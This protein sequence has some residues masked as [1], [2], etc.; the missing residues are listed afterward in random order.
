MTGSN[1]T[2]FSAQDLFWLLPLVAAIVLPGLSYIMA[3]HPFAARIRLAVVMDS[4]VAVVTAIVFVIVYLASG[5][6]LR[7][8]LSV[9]TI[10]SL[11]LFQW[12]LLNT[13]AGVLAESLPIGILADAVPVAIGFGLLW[14]ATRLGEERPFVAVVAGG[15]WA[16]IIAL[17]VM[18]VP[19]VERVPGSTGEAQ[20]AGG[21][22]DVV[23]LILDGYPRADVLDAQFGYD[24][25]PFLDDLAALGFEVADEANSNYSFTYAA[26]SSMLQLDYIFEPGPINDEQREQMRNAL[27]G[28]SPMMR[29]FSE[30]GYEIAYYENAWEGSSCSPYVDDCVRDGLVERTLWNL[31]RSTIFAKLYD[32][33]RPNPFASVSLAHLES[34]GTVT[35]RPNDGKVPRF[36]ILHA[37]LPHQPILLSAECKIVRAT[38]DGG[39]AANT[40]ELRDAAKGLYEEQLDCV[41][42]LVIS[43]LQELISANPGTMVMITG[44]HG[45]GSLLAEGN[46]TIS[47]LPQA[48]FE[49]M[50]ILS[51]YRLPGCEDR[52]YPAITP[53]NGT[54]ALTEC[55]L[56]TSYPALPDRSMWATED[57]FGV[58]VD[59]AGRIPESG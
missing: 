1:R 36:T 8:S 35:R 16:T 30:A 39:F 6:R 14:V 3:G 44:D 25:T 43:G 28:D 7:W 10:V 4:V 29:A 48:L 51:A 32:N 24:N 34:L 19:L 27:S 15:M 49:R 11:L 47:Q 41:N 53:V 12:W 9:T 54:R 42:S 45:S 23:L 13:G 2:R 50:S 26:L 21:A 58:I 31:A 22:P 20:A 38:D 40:A 17:V 5:R 37:L 52:I 57:K 33:L 18:A 59:L 56:G 55:A 46:D